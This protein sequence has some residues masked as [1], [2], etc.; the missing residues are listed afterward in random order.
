MKRLFS[1]ILSV[2][3][4]S[5]FTACKD[6]YDGWIPENPDKPHIT[7]I[8]S[9]TDIKIGAAGTPRTRNSRSQR[10]LD[11]HQHPFLADCV[12]DKRK[13]RRESDGKHQC[14]VKHKK[15]V[16]KRRA[17]L[18]VNEIQHSIYRCDTI[19]RAGVWHPLPQF[20]CNG[21][22]AD[23]QA[24]P[25]LRLGNHKHPDMAPAFRQRKAMPSKNTPSL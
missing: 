17:T 23:F 5:V 25:P 15:R 12:A 11:N 8:I 6:D 16:G 14:G 20:R 19:R 18:C 22:P 10:R 13:S 2:A 24:V 1:I 7:E 21:R 9:P 4:A 3:V